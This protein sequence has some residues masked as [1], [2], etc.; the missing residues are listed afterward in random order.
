MIYMFITV[1]GILFAYQIT[2]LQK[3]VCHTQ[4]I[5]RAHMLIFLILKIKQLFWQE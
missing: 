4:E 5:V 2:F 1:L 3:N